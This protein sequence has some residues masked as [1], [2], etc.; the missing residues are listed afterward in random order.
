MAKDIRPV[1]ATRFVINRVGVLSYAKI[2]MLLMAIIGLVEGLVYALVVAILG[3]IPAGASGDIA[4]N[5]EFLKAVGFAIIIILPII[6][7]VIG[8]ALGALGAWVYNLLAGW[9]GG[10]ELELKE[11]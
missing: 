5:A 6:Y 3:D 1:K 9:V 4:G 11:K 7:A 10:V 2:A 8:F